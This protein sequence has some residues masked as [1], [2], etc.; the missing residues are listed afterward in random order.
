MKSDFDP[1]RRPERANPPPPPDRDS[2]GGFAT[3]AIRMRPTL[4]GLAICE[5]LYEHGDGR[6]EWRRAQSAIEISERRA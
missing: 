1:L 3:G 6:R 2:F 5:E 4:F